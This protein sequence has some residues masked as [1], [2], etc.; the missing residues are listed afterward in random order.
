MTKPENDRASETDDA[1]D[2]AAKYT[3]AL[4]PL[5]GLR[6]QDVVGSAQTIFKA[7]IKEPEIAVSQWLTFLGNLG[8]IATG[9]SERA[10]PAGDKRFNDGAWKTSKPLQALLQS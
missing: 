7:V 2:G 4:N 1:A 5:V 10:L 8:K 6:G 9:Q 3:L